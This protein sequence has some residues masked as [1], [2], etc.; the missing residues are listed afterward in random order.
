MMTDVPLPPRGLSSVGFTLGDKH[1]VIAR[2]P[3]NHL[4]LLDV[5]LR[6]LFFCLDVDNIITVGAY[7]ALCLKRSTYSFVVFLRRSSPR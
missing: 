3:R 6:L 7:S 2:P 4:P 5:P 1:F